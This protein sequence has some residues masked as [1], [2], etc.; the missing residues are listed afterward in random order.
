MKTLSLQKKIVLSLGVL[1]I[2]LSVAF[3]LKAQT[4]GLNLKG[5]SKLVYAMQTPSK[6]T[7]ATVILN[8]IIPTISFKWVIS[9]ESY[10]KVIFST[11]SFNSG[12][13]I[14]SK[15]MQDEKGE[16]GFFWLSKKML[17][18]LS[19]GKTSLYLNG[20]EKMDGVVSAGIEKLEIK[21]NGVMKSL[22]VIHAKSPTGN[23]GADIYVLNDAN[24]PLIIKMR[25]SDGGF[26]L[27]EITE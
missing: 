21:V 18:E 8:T 1:I 14:S 24:N 6:T 17:T 4:P 10:G 11:E 20:S 16:I 25:T 15:L 19:A 2:L 7:D 3:T 23:T 9:D 22:E 5:G 26:S 13:K 27:K 12:R